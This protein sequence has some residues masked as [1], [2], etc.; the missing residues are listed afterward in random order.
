MV[1]K[2]HNFKKKQKNQESGQILIS[3]MLFVVGLILFFAY[4]MNAVEL[5]KI[6]YSHYEESR[7]NSVQE[8]AR[9][10][11]ILNKIS[12]NNVMIMSGILT[13]QKA[14]SIQFEHG[15]YQAYTQPYWETYSVYKKGNG[16]FKALTPG[17]VEGI[18]YDRELYNMNAQR[19]LV[20]A[21][22]LSEENDA[23]IDLLPSQIGKYFVNSGPGAAH[24]LALNLA[25]EYYDDPGVDPIELR[26]ITPDAHL[27]KNN[28]QL[29]RSFWGRKFQIDYN[30]IFGLQR[31]VDGDYERYG[32]AH[33][34]HEKSLFFLR[35]L[36]SRDL[37]RRDDLTLVEYD[38]KN[39]IFSDEIFSSIFFYDSK[40]FEEGWTDS[41][42]EKTAYVKQD[43]LSRISNPYLVCNGRSDKYGSFLEEEDFSKSCVLDADKFYRA[44]FSLQWSPIVT[45]N[46]LL[47]M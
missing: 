45:G 42:G 10:A 8:A 3:G 35:D 39:F 17:T 20:F 41:F 21:K 6:P 15:I 16:W 38:K 32:I 24:C 14:F 27:V 36:Y 43:I 44:F 29:W 23:L 12:Y 46:L 33:V 2:R 28:C 18:G 22:A 9:I 37:N 25:Q 31:R 13:A 47:D 11:N 19:G 4:L 34:P 7:Q 40:I 26:Y 5:G 30:V 1:K